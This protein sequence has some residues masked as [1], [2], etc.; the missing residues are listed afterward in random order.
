MSCTHCCDTGISRM[1]AGLRGYRTHK[2]TDSGADGKSIFCGIRGTLSGV[3]SSLVE[4]IEFAAIV[5][6][7]EASAIVSALR[8]SS[9]HSAAPQ[10]MHAGLYSGARSQISRMHHSCAVSIVPRGNRMEWSVWSVRGSCMRKS[11]S[12]GCQSRVCNERLEGG[13]DAISRWTEP[14]R[15][16][17]LCPFPC[18]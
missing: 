8:A 3:A 16:R 9:M 1:H 4:W 5:R 10:Q 11:R 13:A 6:R 15:R 14:C 12:P 17:Q 7:R 18:N 2:D